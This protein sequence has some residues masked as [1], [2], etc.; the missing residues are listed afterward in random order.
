ML[1]FGGMWETLGLKTRKLVEC[2]ELG[3]M[4]HP[5]RNMLDNALREPWAMEAWLQRF[6]R[7]AILATGLETILVI[8]VK[9]VAAFCT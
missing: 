3:L 9:N 5:R 6:Q 2:C 1:V 7:G 4:G 8:L